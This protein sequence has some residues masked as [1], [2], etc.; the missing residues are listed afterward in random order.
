MPESRPGGGESGGGLDRR[1][2]VKRHGY[3]FAAESLKHS[4]MTVSGFVL[5]VA[6]WF[7]LPAMWALIADAAIYVI[8]KAREP[9]PPTDAR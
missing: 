1:C 5:G 6:V 2:N 8:V 3:E 4:L 9:I 7:W